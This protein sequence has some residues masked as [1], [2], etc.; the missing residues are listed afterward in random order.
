[1]IKPNR[2][3]QLNF[4]FSQSK[5]QNDLEKC[6][7]YQWKNHFNQNDYDGGW[8]SIALRSA[9]GIETDIVSNP[10]KNGFKDTLLLSKCFYFQEVLQTFA[11]PLETVRLLNLAP[12]SEIKTH[13]DFNAG[14]EDGFFRIHIPIKTNDE[15]FFVVDGENLQMKSGECWYANFNLPHSVK[16]NSSTERI[17][18][19][20]DCLRNNWSDEIFSSLGYDFQAEKLRK[21]PSLETKTRILAELR[22][23]NTPT[24]EKLIK[25]LQ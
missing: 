15:V 8:T 5:L 24:A 3:F 16:N 9:S 17:H 11:C 7:H 12:Q 22:K 14:Y 20:I 19:V 10:S 4:F 6:L 25:Q 21:Q 18:L 23:M 2:F 1:M 13:R